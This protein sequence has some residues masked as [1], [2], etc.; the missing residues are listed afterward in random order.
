M[1][2]AITSTEKK[3]IDK[4]WLYNNYTIGFREQGLRKT[5]EKKGGIKGDTWLSS[6]TTFKKNNS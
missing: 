2:I 4:N 5:G 6:W 1:V 3:A